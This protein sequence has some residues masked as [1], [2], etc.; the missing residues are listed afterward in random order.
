M[1]EYQ[2]TDTVD[3]TD[4]NC[5]ITFVKAKVALEELDE[6]DV[7]KVHMNGGEPSENVPRSMKEEGHEV[8]DLIEN[9]DG[10]F[11]LFVKKVGD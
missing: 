9:A 7:L 1:A 4:V 2:V 11:D 8:L 10:T 3:I 5:P 6:G